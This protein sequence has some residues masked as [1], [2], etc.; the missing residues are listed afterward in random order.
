[1]TAKW[2]GVFLVIAAALVESFAQMSLKVGAAGGPKIL[3][4]FYHRQAKRHPL[5]SSAG[6]WIA[7]AVLLYGVEILLYS[8]GLR[9]LNVSVAF[10]LGSL[11]FV[12]VAIL[13]RLFLGEMVGKIRWLGV[14]CILAGAVLLTL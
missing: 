13:S 1:M 2:T 5:G 10:P 12:G 3:I 4:P 6:A 7:L 14:S 11:C 8:L 9:N